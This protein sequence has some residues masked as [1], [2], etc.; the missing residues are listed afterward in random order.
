M[1]LLRS[2]G[3]VFPI[4]I[5]GSP[6]LKRID[7]ALVEVEAKHVVADFHKTSAS[8]QANVIGTHNN[9]FHSVSPVKK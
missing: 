5:L 6:E 7:P 2:P 1:L 9:D 8:G 4:F 3:G